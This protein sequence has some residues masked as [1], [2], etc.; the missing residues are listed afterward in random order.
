MN[1]DIIKG[2]RH[3]I[4]GKLKDHWSKLTDDEITEMQGSYEEL[5]GVLQKSYG[6]QKDKTKEKIQNFL[7]KNRWKEK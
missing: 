5:E 7:E 6:Y 1:Q 2:H 3:E 4:K